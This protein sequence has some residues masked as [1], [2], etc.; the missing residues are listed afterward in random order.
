M[1]HKKSTDSLDKSTDTENKDN[2]I[3]EIMDIEGFSN[4]QANNFNKF[5]RKTSQ[6][7]TP[8]PSY[9]NMDKISHEITK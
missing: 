6:L 4:E 9:A 7:S 8:P 5:Y 2:F 1:R 3:I